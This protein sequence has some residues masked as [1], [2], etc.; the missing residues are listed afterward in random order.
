MSQLF[1]IHQ[2]KKKK[3]LI[4]Q[5]V[6]IIKKGGLLFIRQIVLMPWGAIWVI[7]QRWIK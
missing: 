5:A 3:R 4:Q 1:Q 7:N 6:D 2:K